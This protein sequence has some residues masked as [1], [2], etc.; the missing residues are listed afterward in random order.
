M[1]FKKA[2]RKQT[3]L[4]I[5]ISGPS[6]SGKTFSAL[7]L[8]TGI[9]KKLNGKIAVIDSERGS[10][11]LYSDKFDFDVNDLNP[12]YTTEKYIDAMKEAV[13]GGYSVLVIDSVSHAWA[14]EGGLLNQKEQLDSRGGNSFANW[15]KM[16][17]KQERFISA[18]IHAP[19]HV[20]VTMRSKQEYAQITDGGKLKVQKLGL[21]PV[22]RDG[23]EYEMTIV[24]DVAMNHEA[25]TSKDRTG[26][27]VDKIFQITE[28][29]GDVLIEWLNGGA[30]EVLQPEMINFEKS[31]EE[32]SQD[33]LIVPKPVYKKE[34][35]AE[36]PPLNTD[37][38]LFSPDEIAET[39]K[40][41]IE[42]TK[43]TIPNEALGVYTM[44]GGKFADKTLNKIKKEELYRYVADVLAY[45]K[46]N[47]NPLPPEVVENINNIKQ[48]LGLM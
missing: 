20:I 31:I 43:T 38:P 21:A 14:G 12:P 44:K 27:F 33:S 46:E 24:F 36:P 1:A 40:K 16:T 26:L 3:K 17:P 18:I 39:N 10:A 15:S 35:L 23:F 29:T 34:A 47:K 30:K 9:A 28:Q 13:A 5:G 48:Y 19:I 11:S 22:Q 6:G 25:E 8:A 37:D 41:V 32:V 4:K 2:E 42:Q 7:R 45:Q